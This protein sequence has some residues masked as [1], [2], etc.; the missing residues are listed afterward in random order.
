MGDRGFGR[1]SL[2]DLLYMAHHAHTRLWEPRMDAGPMCC[3]SYD[4][5]PLNPPKVAEDGGERN[6]IERTRSDE[7]R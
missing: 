4:I 3:W 5:Q 1:L 2:K 6:M 7:T